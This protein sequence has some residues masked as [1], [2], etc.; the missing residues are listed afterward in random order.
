MPG[1]S[2]SIRAGKIASLC[3]Q[4]STL[5]LAGCGLG[6]QNI[7]LTCCPTEGSCVC[8]EPPTVPLFTRP[9]QVSESVKCHSTNH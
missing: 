8:E 4:A 1:G 5:T 9:F 7:A 3:L 2:D 6:T